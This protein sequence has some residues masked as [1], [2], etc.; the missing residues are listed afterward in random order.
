MSFSADKLRMRFRLHTKSNL[1]AR[2]AIFVM[3]G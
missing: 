2:F 1:R 3:M